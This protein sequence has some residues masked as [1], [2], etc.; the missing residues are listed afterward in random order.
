MCGRSNSIRQS[1]LSFQ[2][3]FSDWV[4]AGTQISKSEHLEKSNIRAPCRERSKIHQGASVMSSERCD[5]FR[6]ISTAGSVV[7]R[8]DKCPHPSHHPVAIR[9]LARDGSVVSEIWCQCPSGVIT[10][11]IH[12][13]CLPFFSSAPGMGCLLHVVLAPWWMIPCASFALRLVHG[14]STK[15]HCGEFVGGSKV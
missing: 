13:K 14:C 5:E 9:Q 15:C 11:R 7:E 12:Q 10:V 4:R 8:V 2:F 1:E 3:V 6:K